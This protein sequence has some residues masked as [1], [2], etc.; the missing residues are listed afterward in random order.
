MLGNNTRAKFILQCNGT[1]VNTLGLASEDI[2]SRHPKTPLYYASEEGRVEVVKLLLAH[3]DIDV[4]MKLNVSFTA[5]GISSNL[6]NFEV[7]KELLAHPKVDVNQVDAS[8][9]ATE[10]KTP[11]SL[12]SH[13]GHTGRSIWS[14]TSFC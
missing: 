14:W 12:S 1:D 8:L 4:T 11:L 7:V 13:N 3:P 6:G 2:H 10:Q 5:L 9:P